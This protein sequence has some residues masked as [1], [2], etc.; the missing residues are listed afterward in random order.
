ME[1][2]TSRIEN[3]VKAAVD[4]DPGEIADKVRS[5]TLHALSGGALDTAS[6]RAVITA[7]LKGAQEGVERPGEQRAAALREAVRGLD[8]ALAAAAQATQLAIQEAAG[9]TGEFSRQGLKTRLDELGSVESLFVDTLAE[10]ARSATGHARETLRALAE[11]SRASGTAVGG[12]VQAAVGQLAGAL[13]GAAQ[14]GLEA[15]ARTLRN[16]AELFAGLA[17]GVLRGIAD[18]LHSPGDKTGG[19]SE[20]CA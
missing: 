15:G 6:L 1:Q 13:A 10:A 5:V 9:R 8:E 19:S 12:R 18:R 14:E 11:H 4:S 2:D 3:E 16:E 20:D 7:V 17:A